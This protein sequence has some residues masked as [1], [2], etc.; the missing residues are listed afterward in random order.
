MI[1]PDSALLIID[2]QKGSFTNDT[3]RYDSNN[4]INRINQVASVFRRQEFPILYIQH[5]GTGSGAFEKHTEEWQLL[6]ELV[7][8]ESDIIVDKYANDCFYRS[9][10]QPILE[11]ENI[12]NL[13]ISGCAT[14][15]CVESTI[16]SAITK[17]FNLYILKDAHTTA[18]RLH[19][20]AKSIIDHYNWV[21]DNLVPTRGEINLIHA[22]EVI[23]QS[24]ELSDEKV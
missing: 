2:M 24:M 6:D 1:K 17:D 14:D 13:Y 9:E 7:V 19:L 5:D 22:K 3:P 15:F 11:K 21:W 10:L 23:A 12:Q 8:T 18:D 20:D 16:Q 4:V